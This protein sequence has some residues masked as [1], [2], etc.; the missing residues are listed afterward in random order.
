MISDS[1]TFPSFSLAFYRGHVFALA[2]VYSSLIS[3][4][5]RTTMLTLY[6]A[7]Y[8]NQLDLFV[9]VTVF[10][11]LAVPRCF[12]ISLLPTIRKTMHREMKVDN[13]SPYNDL[14][15]QF[16]LSSLDYVFVLATVIAILT[17]AGC[18]C[19]FGLK[20][21]REVTLK[22]WRLK[23]RSTLFFQ[24]QHFFYQAYGFVL[25]T[26]TISLAFAGPS[27][28]VQIQITRATEKLGHWVFSMADGILPLR[29]RLMF[30]L[31]LALLLRRLS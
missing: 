1:K 16:F 31:N 27:C 4:N 8:S 17:F 7:V 20:K 22:W 19:F 23:L 29:P 26:V 12:C 15:L 5:W 6:L 3:I 13:G 18:Y 30:F 28:Y 25:V 9:L 10:L 24:S 11:Y 21:F 2:T 14:N